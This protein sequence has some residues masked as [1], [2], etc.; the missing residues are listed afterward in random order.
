MIY[1][2]NLNRLEIIYDQKKQMSMK[3]EKITSQIMV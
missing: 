2:Y 1:V 3:A